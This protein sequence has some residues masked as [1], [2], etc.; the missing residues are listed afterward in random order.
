MKKT[1]KSITTLIQD[2]MDEN[3]EVVTPLKDNEIKKARK[4]VDIPET[5]LYDSSRNYK[6]YSLNCSSGRIGEIVGIFKT[7]KSTKFCD[8]YGFDYKNC[9][10]MYF[11]VGKTGKDVLLTQLPLSSLSFTKKSVLVENSRGYI[12]EKRYKY[13]DFKTRSLK[14]S[15][16]AVVFVFTNHEK[17]LIAKTESESRLKDMYQQMTID[18]ANSISAYEKVRKKGET[19]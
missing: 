16:K 5:N 11:K 12:T 19:N 2:R 7:P 4:Y 8:K 6:G 15:Y 9:V 17:E 10:D 18:M 3:I 1:S 13:I 14:D